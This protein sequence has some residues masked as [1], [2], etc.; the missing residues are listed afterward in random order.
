MLSS[1]PADSLEE[2]DLKSSYPSPPLIINTSRPVLVP[3]V[4]GA[5]GVVGEVLEPFSLVLSCVPSFGTSTAV[6]KRT[7]PVCPWKEAV[8]EGQFRKEAVLA[9]I[10][11][12]GNV[13]TT[14]A[15]VPIQRRSLQASRAVTRKQAA[16]C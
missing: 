6:R 4:R 9:V 12:S 16:L 2:L 7:C 13:K 14:P 3:D 15:L 5:V 8:A 1:R 10:V 11:G